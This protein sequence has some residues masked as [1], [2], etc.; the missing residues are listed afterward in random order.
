MEDPIERRSAALYSFFA[1]MMR[2]TMRRGFHA[3]R[4]AGIEG[5]RAVRG[6]LIVYANHPSWW[7]PPFFLLLH[8]HVFKGRLA[9][10][11]IDAAALARYRFM[12]RLGL[13]PVERG[14]RRGAASFLRTGVR[15]LRTADTVLWLTPEGRFNDPRA[16]PLRL[17]AGLAHLT[18]AAPADAI[19]LP[20][21]VEYPFWEEKYPEALARFGAPLAAGALRA[22]PRDAMLARLTDA[23]S[24]TMDDL[25]A[26]AIRRDA[27]AFTTVLEGSAGA[28]A[29]YDLY[30]RARAAASGRRFDPA[31]GGGTGTAR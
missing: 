16:R 19:F 30:R 4:A 20:L 25:A 6:P 31:H 15:V 2:Y 21:A 27:S 9:F 13:F 23:L 18:T 7:D 22:L 11:P 8:E 24:A 17:E 26:D 14:T 29:V 12:G 3:V 5:A 10:G 1:P 28:N